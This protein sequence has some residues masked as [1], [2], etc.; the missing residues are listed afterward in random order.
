MVFKLQYR[1]RR[2]AGGFL[3][4]LERSFSAEMLQSRSKLLPS[5]DMLS[6]Y[7]VVKQHTS[8]NTKTQTDLKSYFI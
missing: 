7:S 5:E 1:G 3:L 2:A 8:F 4:L 6:V